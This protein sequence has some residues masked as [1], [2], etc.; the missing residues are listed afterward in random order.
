MEGVM[1]QTIKIIPMEGVMDQTIKKEGSR[2]QE[3]ASTVDKKVIVWQHAQAKN[4]HL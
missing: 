4:T 1:D 3:S 2:S